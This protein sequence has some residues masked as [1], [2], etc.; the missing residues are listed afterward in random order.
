MCSH[1]GLHVVMTL[2]DY[3]DDDTHATYRVEISTKT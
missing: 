3:T 1:D 2:H